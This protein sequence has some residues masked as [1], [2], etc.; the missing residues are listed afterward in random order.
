MRGALRICTV[1]TKFVVASQCLVANRIY[2]NIK[3]N[4]YNKILHSLPPAYEVKNKKKN[5]YIFLYLTK[6]HTTDL[7][8][9]VS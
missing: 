1:E 2:L 8:G 3:P 4:F 6:I 7:K 9:T 5:I